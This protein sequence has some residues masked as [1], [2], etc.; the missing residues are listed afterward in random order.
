MIIG[1]PKEIKNNEFRVAITA[2]GVHEFRTHGHTV[3][4]ERGAG[5]GSGIT[6]EEYSIAGAEIVNE[7][8]DVWGRADMV[9]KVKE[10]IA[11]EYHR[12]RKGLILFTYLHL[13]AEPE[14]TAELINSGVTAIAYETVQEGRTLPAAR[15]DVRGRGP[16]L[17]RS[18]RFL[19]DGS[20]RWQGCPP[21]RRTGRPPGQGCCPRRRRCGNQR[22]CHGA[23]PRC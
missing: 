5:L 3:L 7:A 13:A 9:M 19:P 11:A 12:F 4:V 20:C 1:V 6:D 14:L 21:G 18:R 10:P 17:R 8:D 2:A 23:G 22:R 16:P 15:P